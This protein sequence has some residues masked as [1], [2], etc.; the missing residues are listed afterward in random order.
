MPASRSACT[1]T[2]APRSWPSSPG[3]ATRIFIVATA[4]FAAWAVGGLFEM[5]VA[6]F[7]ATALFAAWAVGGLFEMVVAPSCPF[8]WFEGG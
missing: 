6:P 3:F 1:T 8:C 4:L 5:V 7:V 2:F